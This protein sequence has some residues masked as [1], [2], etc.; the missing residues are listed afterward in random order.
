MT[1]ELKLIRGNDRGGPANAVAAMTDQDVLVAI[2]FWRLNQTSVV[3]AEEANARGAR[4]GLL[5]RQP[6]N[7]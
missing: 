3:A 5:H 6:R 7:S 2:S 4:V 1:E